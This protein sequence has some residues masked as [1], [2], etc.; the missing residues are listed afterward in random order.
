MG[1]STFRFFLYAA[2]HFVLYSYSIASQA[3]TLLCDELE[4]LRPGEFI[5]S[6]SGAFLTIATLRPSKESPS[7]SR[8]ILKGAMARRLSGELDGAKNV[9]W[10][11][12]L[13]LGPV[14]CGSFTAYK[15]SV[16]PFYVRISEN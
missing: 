16:N 8:S 2:L 5:D 14:I 9:R 11:A 6:E 12:A 13:Q 4:G 1:H 15:L 7:V 10:S 3:T